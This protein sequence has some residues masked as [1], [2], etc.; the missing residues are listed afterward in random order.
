[1]AFPTAANSKVTDSITQANLEVL[2]LAPAIAMGELYVATSQALANSAHNATY[3]QQQNYIMADA[4]TK[5]G[6]ALLNKITAQM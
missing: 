2:G 1:M 4:A 3:N 6:V 5:T